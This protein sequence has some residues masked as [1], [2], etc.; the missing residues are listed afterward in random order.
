MEEVDEADDTDDV[1]L[2]R[3]RVLRGMNM[4]FSSSGFIWL[5]LCPP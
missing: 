4:R 3:W 2:F 1:E 5:R